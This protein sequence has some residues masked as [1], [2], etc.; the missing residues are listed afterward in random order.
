MIRSPNLNVII[1][2]L[3]KISPKMARDFGE[4]ENLQSNSFA[5]TKFANACYKAVKERLI[6]D[7]SEFRPDFNIRFLDGEKINDNINAKASF[8]VAP[9]DGLLNFSRAIPSFSNVIALEEIIDGKPEITAIAISNIVSNEVCVA[10]KGSGAFL[11]NRRIRIASHKPL[12]HILCAINNKNLFRSELVHHDKYVLQL[13]NCSSLDLVDLA[14]GK[15]DLAIFDERDCE[16]LNIAS[17]LIK[18]A[19]GF[20]TQKGSVLL[21]G[22]NK[23]I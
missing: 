22:N 8:V 10:Q 11:R 9:I 4:I 16:M 2:A 15:L 19:G 14:A 12:S 18:E 6:E 13:R 3:D 7:L 17:V 1:K 21:V 5:A 23:L 20:I